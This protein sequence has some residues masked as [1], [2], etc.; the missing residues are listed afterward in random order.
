LELKINTNA[1]RL[2]DKLIHQM[3]KSGLTD[4]VFSVDSYTKEE[5][6]S[7]R[8]KGIFDEV[9]KNI[10]RFKDIERNFIPT[11]DVQ[12]ELVV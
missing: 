3:L 7:I 6:E 4:I 12:Q 10:T 2:P 1:T 8:V 5:Y 9:L 11:R